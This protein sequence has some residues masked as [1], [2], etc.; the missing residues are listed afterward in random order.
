MILGC[1]RRVPWLCRTRGFRVEGFKVESVGFQPKELGPYHNH[2]T[3]H[4]DLLIGIWGNSSPLI[5][6]VF[7]DAQVT[8]V[9]NAPQKNSIGISGISC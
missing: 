7:A 2:V 9:R 3:N 4:K 5:V 6:E 8:L 1:R